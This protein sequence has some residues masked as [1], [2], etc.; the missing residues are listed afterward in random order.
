MANRLAR[1]HT[2]RDVTRRHFLQGAAKIGG[3][4][5]LGASSVVVR[6]PWAHAAGPIKVGI[7]TDLTGP[8]GFAGQA[9]ANVA[10]MVV[11]QINNGGGLLGRQIA[12]HIEDTA[13]NES[14]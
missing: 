2:G 9:N 8:I 6:P 14:V 3:A 13:S 4:L 1:G 12:L 10:R 5:A 7:A 11:D